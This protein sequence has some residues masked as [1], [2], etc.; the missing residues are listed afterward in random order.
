MKSRSSPGG[1]VMAVGCRT[2]PVSVSSLT[3]CSAGKVGRSSRRRTRNRCGRSARSRRTSAGRAGGGRSATSDRRVGALWSSAR[4]AFP[5]EEEE[6]DDEDRDQ[7]DHE[8]TEPRLG[9]GCGLAVAGAHEVGSLGNQA[10]EQA[11]SGV[12]AEKD[13]RH[14]R[15]HEDRLECL[16]QDRSDR[17]HLDLVQLEHFRRHGKSVGHDHLLDRQRS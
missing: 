17:E 5:A 2:S 16:G 11:A 1:V 3:P 14:R 9:C 4:S 12:L 15:V 7:S 6:G 10:P 13:L 8:S